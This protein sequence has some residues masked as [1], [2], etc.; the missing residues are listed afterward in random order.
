MNERLRFITHRGKQILLV[1]LS[2]CSPVQ[3]DKIIRHVP[4]VVTAQDRASVLLLADYTGAEVDKEAFRTIEQTAVFDKPFVKRSAWVGAE[5]F[6][7]VFRKNLKSFSG[8]EF[9]TFKTR[10]DALEWLTSDS[11]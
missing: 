9:P 3:V 11:Q 2:N 6:P 1:D 10:E 7:E 5:H 4:D 8:R